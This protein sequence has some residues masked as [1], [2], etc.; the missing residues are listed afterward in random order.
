MSGTSVASASSRLLDTEGRIHHA[1]ARRAICAG[2]HRRLRLDAGVPPG[3]ARRYSIS[4]APFRARL[5][6]FDAVPP[7]GLPAVISLA[8]WG[9]VWGAGDLAVAEACGRRSLLGVGGGDWRDRPQRGRA[10]H[11]LSAQGH[12]CGG[13]LGPEAPRCSA[14]SQWCLGFGPGA[15]DALASPRPEPRQCRPACRLRT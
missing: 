10:V 14:A 12:A 7:L 8:F 4:R 3:R 5:M 1:S 15:V 13:W 6:T 11:R 9:G 2:L